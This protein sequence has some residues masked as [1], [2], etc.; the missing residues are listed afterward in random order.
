VHT[1]RRERECSR[2]SALHTGNSSSGGS[3]IG[4]AQQLSERQHSSVMPTLAPQQLGGGSAHAPR[5]LAR[6]QRRLQQA[7]SVGTRECAI[8]RT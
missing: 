6:R 3:S 1:I 5:R 8:N 7:S 4:V 2:H